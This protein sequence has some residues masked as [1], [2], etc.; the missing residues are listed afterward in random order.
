MAYKKKAGNK[1]TSTYKKKPYTKKY[2]PNG[3]YQISRVKKGLDVPGLLVANNNMATNTGVTLLNG[4]TPGTQSSQRVG[5]KIAIASINID[6]YIRAHLSTD[7]AALIPSYNSRLV[8]VWDKQPNGTIPVKSDIF[9]SKVTTTG[10]E[11][12]LYIAG[13]AYKN[14]QR[15]QVLWDKRL[16]YNAGTFGFNDSGLAV[17]TI[18]IRIKKFLKVNLQTNYQGDDDGIGSIA[19][20]ALFLIHMT[21][22]DEQEVT[23]NF[24]SRIRYYDQ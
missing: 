1:K 10:V 22:D 16:T 6:G 15:F 5:R 24:M 2:N 13:V 4:C 20:G 14:M 17:V 23:Y 21:P 9:S 18:D 8:L 3:A 7:D 12:G 11:T 19:S